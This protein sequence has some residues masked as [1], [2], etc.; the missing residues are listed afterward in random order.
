MSSYNAYQLP[1]PITQGRYRSID[2]KTEA[3]RA[4]LEDER[5][6]QMNWV[7]AKTYR[8]NRALRLRAPLN[9]NLCFW[10]LLLPLLFTFNAF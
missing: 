9:I 1:K 7:V 4:K 5:L 3:V 2:L 10:W 6:D 8:R